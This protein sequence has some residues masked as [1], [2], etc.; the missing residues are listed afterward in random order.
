MS[1]PLRCRTRRALGATPQPFTLLGHPPRPRPACA[2]AASSVVACWWV[3]L[4]PGCS[5]EAGAGPEPPAGATRP[6][7]GRGLRADEAVP[8]VTARGWSPAVTDPDHAPRPGDSR[9]PGRRRRGDPERAAGPAALHEV[10]DALPR[11][12]R[13]PSSAALLRPLLAR[14][15]R[16]RGR[17]GRRRCGRCGTRPRTARSGTPRWRSRGT[18]RPAP[19]RTR[20]LPLVPH[21]VVT[22]AW[23]D[24]VDDVAAHLV[25]ASCRFTEEVTPWCASGPPTTT[26]GCGGRRCSASSAADRT[27]TSPC[28]V[29]HRA[30]PR[31][32]VRS[33][34]ARP[35]AGRCATYA[36]TDPDWVRAEVARLDDRL[37]GAL[38]AG[39]PQAP[40]LI[41]LGERALTAT[42]RQAHRRSGNVSLDS[43][44]QGLRPRTRG[45]TMNKLMTIGALGI[46]GLFTTGVMATQAPAAFARERRRLLGGEDHRRPRSRPCRGRPLTAG[47]TTVTTTTGATTATTTAPPRASPRSRRRSRPPRRRRLTSVSSG[48]APRDSAGPLPV[49]PG[50]LVKRYPIP[51]TVSI[52]PAPNLRRR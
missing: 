19:G 5:W 3:G 7:S 10:G 49:R 15:R 4:V 46:A 25:G 13:R 23:W 28:C 30:E 38:A 11:H 36:R 44:H 33:G 1:P 16:R 41:G 40:V 29:R 20:P 26:S 8:R 27:P 17:S 24:L 42:S 48:P 52:A 35:S 31:R 51:R 12:H 14:T 2:A 22:G 32:P 45:H 21:L 39:G 37:L 50:Q 43:S 47:G 34:S 6:Q 18:A 9:D